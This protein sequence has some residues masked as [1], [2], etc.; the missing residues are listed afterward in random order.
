MIDWYVTESPFWDGASFFVSPEMWAYDAHIIF[1]SENQPCLLFSVKICLITQC[2]EIF[3]YII[4]TVVGFSFF[5]FDHLCFWV[6]SYIS[7][8]ACNSAVLYIKRLPPLYQTWMAV[9]AF[10]PLKT[11]IACLHER[12]AHRIQ[13]TRM[14]GRHGVQA[15]P[16]DVQLFQQSFLDRHFPR[17]RI[18]SSEKVCKDRLRLVL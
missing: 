9:S 5:N 3:P 6:G 8:F 2:R 14:K 18:L 4:E 16:D 17:L 13:V 15:V 12:V 1:H 10:M 7:K 11:Q